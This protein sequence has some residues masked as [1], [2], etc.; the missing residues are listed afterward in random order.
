MSTELLSSSG[1]SV[2]VATVEEM[3]SNNPKN[4]SSII[5]NAHLVNEVSKIVARSASDRIFSY[6]YLHCV[7]SMVKGNQVVMMTHHNPLD[8]D[9]RGI[10]NTEIQKV[11]D[12]SALLSSGVAV[13]WR[14]SFSGVKGEDF[15]Y[16]DTANLWYEK[17]KNV[18]LLNSLIVYDLVFNLWESPLS[19]YYNGEGVLTMISN[20]NEQHKLFKPNVRKLK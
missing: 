14:K 5:T 1:L 20:I 4:L 15:R 11:G 19:A 13:I 8:L 16:R 7:G 10:I 17:L 3:R 12:E 9:E 18:Y 2:V 6:G